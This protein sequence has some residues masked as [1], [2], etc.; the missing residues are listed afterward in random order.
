[1]IQVPSYKNQPK[2]KPAG[3]L[4]LGGILA[5]FLASSPS[6]ATLR[7]WGGTLHRASVTEGAPGAGSLAGE[8]YSRNGLYAYLYA[9]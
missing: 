1:M 7:N 9:N 8:L 2:K 4:V 3:E 6:H 5:I